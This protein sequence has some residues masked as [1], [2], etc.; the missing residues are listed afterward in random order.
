MAFYLFK[1]RT[2]LRKL[3]LKEC[4]KKVFKKPY[5]DGRKNCLIQN[6]YDPEAKEF[7]NTVRVDLTSGNVV[8][9][10]THT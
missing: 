10:A 8:S 7:F 6:Y 1:E 4:N 3:A 2:K 5:I 9:L